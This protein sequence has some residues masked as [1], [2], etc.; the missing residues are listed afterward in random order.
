MWVAFCCSRGLFCGINPYPVAYAYDFFKN[1]KK[2]SS[3][4]TETIV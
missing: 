4:Q 2:T 1:F 3:Y